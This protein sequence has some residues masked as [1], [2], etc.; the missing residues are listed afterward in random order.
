M[1]KGSGAH[2]AIDIDE[3]QT[4][5]HASNRNPRVELRPD[6]E[7]L[8][9]LGLIINPPIPPKRDVSVIR[10][11]AIITPPIPVNVRKAD[12]LLLCPRGGNLSVP[13]PGWGLA[14]APVAVVSRQVE[15]AVG[16]D[17]DEIVEAIGVHVNEVEAGGVAVVLREHVVYLCEFSE[18]V[19]G[20]FPG[21]SC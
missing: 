19:G 11:N 5:Q 17:A 13:G 9:V 15:V 18:A 14:A 7:R 6:T 20:V 16:V 10:N 21:R 1:G 12:P 3:P 2:I 4:V 8:P